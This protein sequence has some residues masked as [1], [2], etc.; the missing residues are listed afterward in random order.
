L[1]DFLHVA[2][3]AC[4][5]LL[6]SLRW[7]PAVSPATWGDGSAPCE[8]VG[9]WFGPYLLLTPVQVQ[10]RSNVISIQSSGDLLRF[11]HKK[12]LFPP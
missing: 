9:Q 2:I 3:V 10:L 7:F 6:L 11:M 4:R 5:I 8:S 1:V 12:V